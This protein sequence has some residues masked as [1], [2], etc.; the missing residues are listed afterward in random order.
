MQVIG[1]EYTRALFTLT[2][3]KFKTYWEYSLNNIICGTSDIY[4]SAIRIEK[5]RGFNNSTNIDYWLVIKDKDKWSHCTRLTGLRAIKK[6]RAF[7]G[8]QKEPNKGKPKSL[9]ILQFSEDYKMLTVDYFPNFYP[10]APK[11]RATTFNAHSY[12]FN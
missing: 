7:Y 12:Y 11:E 9:L 1:K 8:D 3:D 6:G 5:Q 4:T 2:N 10:Y